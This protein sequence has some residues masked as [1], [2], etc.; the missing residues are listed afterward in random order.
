MQQ[1][2]VLN[3]L[4]Q[5]QQFASNLAEQLTAPLWIYLH[6]DL[7]AG[8]TTMVQALLKAMGVTD[9]VTSPTFALLETYDAEQLQVI[10]MDLYRVEHPEEVKF[11]GY[12][13]LVDAQTIG[14][15]EWPEKATGLI[16]DADLSITIEMNGVD[17]VYHCAA[18]SKRGDAIVSGLRV[19]GSSDV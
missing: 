10:H 16:P 12:E 7:G 3:E 19:M 15:I 2:M 4:Q 8:K 6:G 1:V 5:L 9:V 11:I 17:R 14:I 18:H 13:D